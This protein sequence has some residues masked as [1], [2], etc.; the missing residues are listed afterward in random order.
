MYVRKYYEAQF[1]ADRCDEMIRHA[2]TNVPLKVLLE[3][4]DVELRLLKSQSV[5]RKKMNAETDAVLGRKTEFEPAERLFLGNN[6]ETIE[7]ATRLLLAYAGE[8]YHAALPAIEAKRNSEAYD[9]SSRGKTTLTAAEKEMIINSSAR[10]G[11]STGWVHASWMLEN[12]SSAW[13][14]GVGE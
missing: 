11:L 1:G 4:L 6:S 8:D 12:G 5:I 9:I 14:S 2:S 13:P 7:A 10:G 3:K